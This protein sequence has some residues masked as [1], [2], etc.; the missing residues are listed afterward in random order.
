MDTNGLPHAREVTTADVTDRKGAVHTF[1]RYKNALAAVESILADGGY[2]GE[3][4]A[5]GVANTLG[6]A[7]ESAKR[8]K[9][10]PLSIF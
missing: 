9:P 5:E 2:S 6:A 3:P 1:V 10:H 4:F 8:N 7:V